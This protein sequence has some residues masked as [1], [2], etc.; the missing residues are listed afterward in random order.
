DEEIQYR[1]LGKFPGTYYRLALDEKAQFGHK[2]PTYDSW[3]YPQ[4][5]RTIR[6]FQSR[7]SLLVWKVY[8]ERLDGFSN[9]DHPSE[10]IPGARDLVLKGQPVD[11]DKNRARYDLDLVGKQMPPA[12]AV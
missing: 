7:R 10:S 5:S 2:P 1:H 6:K 9:D 4:A 8:G 11:K 12:K 3:G